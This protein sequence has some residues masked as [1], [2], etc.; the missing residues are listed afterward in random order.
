MGSKFNSFGTEKFEK[1]N[2]WD[3]KISL[4]FND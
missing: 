2:F 4:N 1:F 3:T